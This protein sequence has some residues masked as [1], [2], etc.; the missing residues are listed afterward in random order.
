L[1]FKYSNSLSFNDK[2]EK[3]WKKKGSSNATNNSTLSL[4][5]SAYENS[6]EVS[7]DSFNESFHKSLFIQKQKQIN[8]V[9]TFV[10]QNPFEF[11]RQQ[12]DKVPEPEVSQFKGSLRLLNPNRGIMDCDDSDD[13]L[14]PYNARSK[15]LFPQKIQFDE[16]WERLKKVIDVILSNGQ[17]KKEEREWHSAFSDVYKLC[18][19]LPH[20]L[21]NLLYEKVDATIS[22][23]VDKIYQASQGRQAQNFL[24]YFMEQNKNIIKVSALL[25][26]MFLHLNNYITHQAKELQ[27]EEVLSQLCVK[28][29]TKQ[30]HIGKLVI[31]RW[32]D[33]VLIPCGPYL[34]QLVLEQ[35]DNY[36]TGKPIEMADLI[37][38]CVTC[39][40][41]AE[42]YE[43]A[44]SSSFSDQRDELKLYKDNFELPLH[45]SCRDYYLLKAKEWENLTDS[46]AFIENVANLMDNEKH[47]AKILMHPSTVTVIEQWAAQAL[48]ADKVKNLN[49]SFKSHMTHENFNGPE[50]HKCFNVLKL[51]EN[52][53]VDLVKDYENYIIDF[54]TKKFGK[55]FND[56]KVFVNVVA[57]A[58]EK[59]D[60]L[61]TKT[62][63]RHR[64]FTEIMDRAL[65]TIVN[66]DKLSKP[67]DKLAR[68]SDA[69]LRKSATPDA[70][71]KPENLG[72]ALKYLNDKEQ[73]E[74]PYQM[75]LANR[76]LGRTSA[77]KLQEEEM[78]EL[79]KNMCG[80]DF[81]QKFTRM[82]NDMFKSN[83]ESTKFFEENKATP[84]VGI[85]FIILQTGAWPLQIGKELPGPFCPE[86]VSTFIQSF[87][88]F[89]TGN[90]TGRQL[91][92]AP[93][94]STVD[95]K[96][97]Y[98]D[99]SYSVTMTSIH[100]DILCCFERNDS[101][102]LSEV[103]EL[104]RLTTDG[105][106][107]YFKTLFEYQVLL[108]ADK[109][110]HFC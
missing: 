58:H 110:S 6:N 97:T 95:V 66:G 35:F 77:G 41:T 84:K 47:L 98:L 37:K 29:D 46:V 1:C 67:G 100:Y 108:C 34:S 9:S 55:D 4:H 72:I 87:T 75:L 88:S 80:S 105:A 49:L 20:P 71:R 45:K 85:E 3:C 27:F 82:L 65:R 8:P 99:K 57:E 63:D 89:Y 18:S 16:I 26:H 21:A 96:L 56:P 30:Y 28:S 62:F 90:H 5:I 22:E 93:S 74:K 33:K 25:N 32:K 102:L 81:V 91:T 103:C 51:I 13:N 24:E 52:G 42:A 107:R 38:N 44:E 2:T 104:S 109:V 79:M 61:T 92:W 14:Y 86:E 68:Y 43:M 12:N 69:M 36:R 106:K 50:L 15:N 76:L 10:S 17:L 73:F 7:S 40:V 101:F 70:E 48:V 54:T 53:L 19:A 11:Q 83:E 94:L 31:I 64:E 39:Y 60:K 59:F 78:I 23:H